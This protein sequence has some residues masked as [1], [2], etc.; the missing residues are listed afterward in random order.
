MAAV[1][2]RAG[3]TVWGGLKR[4]FRWR[5]VLPL[6]R[7]RHAPEHSARAVAVGLFW[8]FTPTFGV[9]MALCCLHWWVS[10]TFLGRDFNV[11]VAMAWTWVTNVFTVGPVYYA[12]FLIGQV[13]LGNWS[14]LTGYRGFAEFLHTLRGAAG[15][16]PFDGNP[17]HAF[18]RS[19]VRGWGLSIVVGSV[20][21][22]VLAHV[23][24]YQLS[25]RAVRRWRRRRR[26]AM[27]KRARRQ[28]R[29]PGA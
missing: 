19:V 21:V 6:I 27:R 5:L 20:P 17:W 28:G 29:R 3:R 8:A 26:I 10:R 18:F 11:V 25:L 24:G 12:C 1:G 15:V 16:V 9:Q 7:S 4:T 14:D 2:R 13:L 22:A 23:L